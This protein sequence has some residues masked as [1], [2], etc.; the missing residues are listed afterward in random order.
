MR[1]DR[2]Q[3]KKKK[4]RWTSILL[5]CLLLIGAV[6]GYAY[7]QFNQ[8]VNQSL[9]KINNDNKQ[10]N[11]V[12][13]FEGKKDQYGDTNILLL[14]SDARGKE[15]ARADTIM[16][17]HYNEDKGT[18]KLTSIMR[19]SYVEIP[20]YGKHKINS[21]FAR[22]GPELIRKTI[23]QNFDIDLQYYAIVDF[24]G[25]VQL[26]DE[27]FPDGVEINVEKKMEKNIYMTLEPGLQRLN[28]TQMLGYVRFRYDAM[29]DFGRVER[30][31]KAV[32]AIREQLSGFKTITKLPKLIGVLSPYVNTNI[33]TADALF[34][35]KDFL[36]SNRGTMATL[37]IPVENSFT[38]PRI[39]GEGAVLDIDV[40]KNKEALHQ[41]ITQ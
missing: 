8:G 2:Y 38:E 27:A 39:Q 21:A 41:F 33:D 19:D 16:I 5:V 1:V 7:F 28:G 3:Q 9:K 22:G 24:D 17:A 26:I 11:E 14:G 31:Q 35:G 23:K 12:Y 20:G 37:R 18:F 15:K 34:M 10:A 32:K 25:F 13:T 36:S 29:S 4:R 6:A 40:E 30:Q